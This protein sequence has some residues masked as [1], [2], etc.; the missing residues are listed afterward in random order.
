MQ[1]PSALPPLVTYPTVTPFARTGS[2][3]LT[4]PS[5]SSRTS[6]RALSASPQLGALAH[7]PI[8]AGRGSIVLGRH[9]D[10]RRGEAGFQAQ[11]LEGPATGGDEALVA[12]GFPEQVPQT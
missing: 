12:A 10:P 3:P 7:E 9:V 11:R 4:S 8:E 2:P 1:A 6:R 5:T